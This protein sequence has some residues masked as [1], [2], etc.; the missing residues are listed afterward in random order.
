MEAFTDYL[1]ATLA[2]YRQLLLLPFTYGLGRLALQF[3]PFVLFLEFPFYLFIFLGLLRYGWRARR[4]ETAPASYRPTVSCIILCYGEG[5]LVRRTIRSLAEQRYPGTI[6][7]LAVVDGAAAN[8][9]TLA[10]AEEMVP[11]VRRLPN[12][13]LVVLPKWQRGGRVSSMNLG[14]RLAQG[15][16]VM[17]IDADTTFANDMVH[18]AT[19]PFTDP[20]VVSVAGNLRVQNRYAN[21]LTRLQDLE[22]I[23]SIS[24][25]KTGLSEF[26]VVNN[27]SGAF[28]IHR[29]SFLLAIGGWD[30]GTAE[31]LDLTMRTKAYF[32]RHPNLAIRFAPEALG[33]TNV[34]DTLRGLLQQRLRWDG[35]LTYLYFKKHGKSFQR[36]LFGWRNLIAQVWYGLVFQ[37]IIPFLITG[38]LVLS[39]LRHPPPLTSALYL[40]VYTAYL[41]LT[42]AFFLVFLVLL[43]PE[44]RKD[45]PL[46]AVVPLFPVYA[47]GIRIWSAWACLNELFLEQHK[48]S[49]MA[50]W[51]VLRKTKF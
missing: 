14:L 26:N 35:D 49:S 21:L 17:A 43:S 33:Y 34:P 20:N 31:D 16:I 38:Y 47:L 23:V 7:L 28:G 30:S 42:L 18:H 41:L 3:F 2:I 6:E 19:R 13:R 51:W 45:A 4:E 12:R 48:D 50:P 11:L 9:H 44:P 22:Y 8:R 29:R 27:V 32:G 15:E 36:R 25:G 40:A 39:W 1:A 10:A 37:V 24:L 5:E 46:L